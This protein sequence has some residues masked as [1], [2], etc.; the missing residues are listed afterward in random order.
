MPGRFHI[1]TS[2]GLREPIGATSVVHHVPVGLL[3]SH[4]VFGPHT[5]WEP[6]RE[7]DDRLRLARPGCLM[8]RRKNA[9]PS[10][11]ATFST[12]LTLTTRYAWPRSGATL[13]S[14]DTL[15]DGIPGPAPAG[16]PA[17]ALPA[18]MGS[19]VEG[20]VVV[21]VM[22]HMGMETGKGNEVPGENE[23]ATGSAEGTMV[24]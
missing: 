21:R 16:D 20:N 4:M 12:T 15:T 22:G 18:S 3:V 2:T 9:W 17:A 24:R 11:G 13:S 14:W 10:R 7:R 1:R 19:R 8:V 5:T 23:E 6:L